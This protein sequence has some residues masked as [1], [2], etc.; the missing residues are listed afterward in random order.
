MVLQIPA[1]FVRGGPAGG[2]LELALLFL[3]QRGALVGVVLATGE[4]A[5]EHD[6]EFAGGR[7]DRFAVPAPGAKAL[8]ER[9]QRAGLLDDAPRGFDQRPPCGG[10]PAL[11]DLARLGR[12]L[13]GLADLR[14]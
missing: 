7:D 4:H 9:A 1:A 13:A 2:Q 3:G 8:I 5:P 10:R 12:C 14:V 11:G 6:D